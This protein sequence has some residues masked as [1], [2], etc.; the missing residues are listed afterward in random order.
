MVAFTFYPLE[1]TRQ[2][3]TNRVERKGMG[4]CNFFKETVHSKGVK[5][6]F[7]CVHLFLI[8]LIIFRG[9]YFGIY[10]SLKRHT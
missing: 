3:L 2:Q 4:L 1:Y 7:Q 8:G 10:D 6:L 9:T 5:G